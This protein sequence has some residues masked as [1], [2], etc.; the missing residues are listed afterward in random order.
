MS[1]LYHVFI[2]PKEGV[3]REAVE[4]ALNAAPDWVRYYHKCYVIETDQ[5]AEYW[6]EKL[7]SL[8]E[9]SG[10]LFICKFD[11]TH[12]HGRMEKAFWEWYQA[13]APR[14]ND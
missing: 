9:P 4:T 11:K 2:L 14:A 5:T 1:A 13:K 3:T 7:K 6:F 8:V 12:Y 10:H